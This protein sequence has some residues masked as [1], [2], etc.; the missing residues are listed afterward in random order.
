[1]TRSNPFT[2]I[3]FCS[4]KICTFNKQNLHFSCLTGT[5]L[6]H[7]RNH[8]SWQPLWTQAFSK[9]VTHSACLHVYFP[10]HEECMVFLSA[11]ELMLG[12]NVTL[13]I[14]HFWYSL[15]RMWAG[16]EY[17][18]IF[19][20]LNERVIKSVV[21]DFK[22]VPIPGWNEM[23]TPERL[24]RNTSA[25]WISL[26]PL[27]LS[28]PLS[29]NVSPTEPVMLAER[30]VSGTPKR[31]P[32]TAL[33]PQIRGNYNPS[34]L[35]GVSHEGKGAF[36]DEFECVSHSKSK[37]WHWTNGAFPHAVPAGSFWLQTLLQG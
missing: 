13:L 32:P 31:Y 29:W 35:G 12:Q 30:K 8:L 5:F 26:Y 36:G 33:S 37:L 6:V 14:S 2:Y 24:D 7:L 20:F 27:P 1:M 15:K 16:Q 17:T 18:G 25:P 9:P 23:T 11:T 4:M 22:Q 34:F 21:T 10:G 28:F 19:F 3:M